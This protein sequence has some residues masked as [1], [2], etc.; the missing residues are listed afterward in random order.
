MTTIDGL[1]LQ[2]LRETCE[3]VR[4]GIGGEMT[5]SEDDAR[6]LIRLMDERD[7]RLDAGGAIAD[8]D[9][10]GAELAVLGEFEA[11]GCRYEHAGVIV[12]DDV[13][14]VRAA[15][16]HLFRRVVLVAPTSAA[17]ATEASS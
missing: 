2:E 12:F 13:E 3:E 15:A 16:P 10:V 14:S 9:L 8:S 11:D 1:A 4:D 6:L 7:A 5:L 17:P